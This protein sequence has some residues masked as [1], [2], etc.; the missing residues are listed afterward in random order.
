[1]KFILC[2]VNNLKPA[3][4]EKLILLFSF[5]FA[6]LYSATAQEQNSQLKTDSTRIKPGTVKIEEGTFLKVKSL[7]EISS[8]IASEGDL[9]DFSVYEDVVIKGKIVLKEGS[10]VKGH[11]EEAEKA[12]GVGKQG[13]LRI[14]FDFAKAADGTKIPLRSTR[15]GFEGEDKTTTSVALAVV[16]SPLFLLKK[17][18]EAK[19]PAGKIMEAYVARDVEVAVN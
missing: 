3:I 15:A 17:G 19:I 13:S 7:S 11:V 8:K 12:K 4:M 18:K 16:V 9:L 5:V 6:I 10:V 1:M 2:S 14:Q